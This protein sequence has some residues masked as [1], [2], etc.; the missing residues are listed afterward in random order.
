MKE[1]KKPWISKNKRWVWLA[2]GIIIAVM[3]LV[4]LAYAILDMMNYVSP[5][6]C[7]NMI[8][9]ALLEQKATGYW[10][11]VFAKIASFLPLLVLCI[12]I[13]WLIHGVGFRI[14]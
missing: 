4:F 10:E 9:K 12:G 3:I 5:E 11:I 7:N 14:M 1:K 13:A 8:E 6:T 2:I